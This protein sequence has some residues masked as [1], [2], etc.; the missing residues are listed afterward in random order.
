VSSILEPSPETVCSIF[1]LYEHLFFEKETEERVR[2]ESGAVM[3]CVSKTTQA[4]KESLQ[5][6]ERQQQIELIALFPVFFFATT[7]KT[8]L[9]FLFLFSMGRE[10][11]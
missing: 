3:N 11:T 10:L 8:L 7:M 2:E 5:T 6:I 1:S 4:N 9:V